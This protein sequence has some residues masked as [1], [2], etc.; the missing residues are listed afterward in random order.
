MKSKELEQALRLINKVLDDPRVRPG[1][2]DQLRKAKRELVTV[3]RSGKVEQQ[4]VFR[5]IELIAMVMLEIVEHEA[6]I[7]RSE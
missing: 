1:H 5:A 6:T 4:R 2:G 7:Q 3:A